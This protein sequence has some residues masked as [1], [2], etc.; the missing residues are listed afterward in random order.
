VTAFPRWLEWLHRILF[1]SDPIERADLIFVFA[2]HRSRKFWAVRLFH[3]GWAPRVLIST[4]DP[5]YIA[6][7]V[8]REIGHSGVPDEQIW[9]DIANTA[10]LPSPQMG[11]FFVC[12]DDKEWSVEQISVGWFGT[13]SET[14]ALAQWLERHPSIRS[15]LIVSVGIHLRRVEMCCQQLIPQYCRIRLV[16]VPPHVADLTGREQTPEHI[17][18]RGILLEWVKVLMYRGILLLRGRHRKSRPSVSDLG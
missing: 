3:E 13:L 11:Q 9:T 7:L 18:T 2:G 14:E 6:R 15:L 5:P 17:A 16:A 12:L 10:A 1:R 4:G 8:R